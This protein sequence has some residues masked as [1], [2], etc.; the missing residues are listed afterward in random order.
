[1]EHSES[2]DLVVVVKRKLLRHLLANELT[3]LIRP[4]S[5]NVAHSIATS[6]ENDDWH[7]KALDVANTIGVAVHAQ[8]EAAK[9]VS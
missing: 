4:S 8:V 6:T 2:T 5:G 1:M 9:S 3:R 7:P